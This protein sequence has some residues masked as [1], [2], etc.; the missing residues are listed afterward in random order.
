MTY[1]HRPF[2]LPPLAA[3]KLSGLAPFF[4]QNR[5]VGER[6]KIYIR[7]IVDPVCGRKAAPV[8]IFL[9]LSRRAMFRSNTLI[10]K[11]TEMSL[12]RH[13]IPGHLNKEFKQH[14][15]AQHLLD[16]FPGV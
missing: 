3:P 5:I 11:F 6:K 8:Q 13:P 12:I 7:H 16:I 1:P 15:A 14:L 9:L 4:F 2:S 10:A